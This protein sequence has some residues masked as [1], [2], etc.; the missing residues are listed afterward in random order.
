[1]T[2]CLYIEIPIFIH[3]FP[4][5]SIDYINPLIMANWKTK[6]NPTKLFPYLFHEGFG[7]H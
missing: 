2:V 4:S 6:G 1:M 7:L 3:S 5:S